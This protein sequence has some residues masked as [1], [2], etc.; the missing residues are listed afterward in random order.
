[1]ITI[2]YSPFRS[3]LN[4]IVKKFVF[5]SLR[6]CGGIRQSLE[7]YSADL[8]YLTDTV[9]FRITFTD[10]EMYTLFLMEWS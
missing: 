1:M 2:E 8:E 3:E 9:G 10:E 5:V 6:Q 4:P 7:K